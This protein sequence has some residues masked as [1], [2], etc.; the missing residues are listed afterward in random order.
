[1][2]IPSLVTQ[3]GTGS[4]V[5]LAG[6]TIIANL[7][8]GIP[9]ELFIILLGAAMASTGVF[10]FWLVFV[11]V[12]AMLTMMDNVLYWLARGGNKL[13][14]KL[15]G[16]IFGS[17]FEERQDFI[18]KHIV[19]IVVISRFVVQVRFLG[20]FLAGAV[21]M[22]WKKFQAWNSMALAAYVPLMLWVGMYFGD[23]IENI[24][25]GVKTVSNS[26]ATG[27][28]VIGVVI[29]LALIH[30]LFLRW[31]RS[32]AKHPLA[33]MGIEKRKLKKKTSA[34]RRKAKK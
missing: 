27:A 19:K 25:K 8:P 4:I 2:D 34:K 7:F 31:I 24:I 28:V 20:P 13:V 26:I 6:L 9:E 18:Q 5:G 23:R 3:I 1:M 12:W 17:H 33:F 10:P 22:P 29:I 32:G 14:Y 11:V 15:K 21:K 16:K 30:R